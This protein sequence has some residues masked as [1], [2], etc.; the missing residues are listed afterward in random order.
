M[1]TTTATT[2][3]TTTAPTDPYEVARRFCQEGEQG[4][5]DLSAPRRVPATER[6]PAALVATDS[7]TLIVISAPSYTPATDDPFDGHADFPNWRELLT[8]HADAPERAAVYPIGYA[9]SVLAEAERVEREKCKAKDCDGGQVP[10]ICAC[11]NEH[12]K[13]CPDCYGSGKGEGTTRVSTWKAR[14]WGF[15]EAPFDGCDLR[16]APPWVSGIVAGDEDKRHTGRDSSSVSVPA[17][18]I[19]ALDPLYLTRALTAPRDLG[20][21]SCRVRGG[22]S[23]DV[24]AIFEA[25]ERGVTVFVMPLSDSRIGGVGSR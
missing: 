9:L 10:C 3:T 19:A 11:D 22:R 21:L 16:A 23:L 7:K 18:H 15:R 25:P 4:R 24:P 5:Y 14:T 17:D 12:T 2:A 6:A 20:A 1:T 13:R 8:I